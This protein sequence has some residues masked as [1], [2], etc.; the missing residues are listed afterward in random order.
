LEMRA[1]RLGNELCVQP[2]STVFQAFSTS[3][4]EL[5]YSLENVGQITS[6]MVLMAD[7]GEP[8]EIDF[9]YVVDATK[10]LINVYGKYGEIYTPE[11]LIVE[12]M[13]DLSSPD[14]ET[15][16]A[17]HTIHKATAWRINEVKDVYAKLMAPLQAVSQPASGISF[18]F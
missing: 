1:A 15:R 10:K 9:L 6:N 8:G 2:V 11:D 17:I 13:T 5:Y 14:D 16:E 4:A 12:G 18:D 3:G 7:F